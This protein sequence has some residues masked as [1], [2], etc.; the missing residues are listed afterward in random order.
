LGLASGGKLWV[1]APQEGHDDASFEMMR[2]QLRQNS[3]L[4]PGLTS[5]R[6]MAGSDQPDMQFL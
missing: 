1:G 3:S 6:V 4:A 2:P 5:V